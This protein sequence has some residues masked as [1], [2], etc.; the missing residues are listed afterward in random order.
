[1]DAILVLS[2]AIG[3]C[4]LLILILLFRQQRQMH[5]LASLRTT[6]EALTTS[7]RKLQ[8]NSKTQEEKL[9]EF[10]SALSGMSDKLQA[11]TRQS[12]DQESQFHEDLKKLTEK[13][14]EIE[15]A[16]PG[17]RMYT[18]AAKLVSSGASIEEVMQ[19]CDIPRAEAELL[20][21][22]HTRE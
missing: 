17:A 11:L 18:K 5:H 15:S 4:I 9:F 3:I 10:T 1:M 20:M 16:D 13:L 2:A 22:L 14:Q 19:E 6:H 21:N 12:K 8:S 7:I